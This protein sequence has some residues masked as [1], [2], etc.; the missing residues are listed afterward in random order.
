MRRMGGLRRYMPITYATLVAGALALAGF[1]LTAGFF[2]KDE[3]L[4]GT[5][6]EGYPLA[7]IVGWIVAAM[8]AFYTF[9]MIFMTF[10]GR[11]RFDPEQVHPHESPPVMTLPL[12]A[13]AIPSLLLGLLVGLPAE[14]GPI[15]QWLGPVFEGGGGH[16]AATKTMAVAAAAEEGAHPP[17]WLTVGGFAA[18]TLLSIAGIALAWLMYGTGRIS[19]Q[20]VGR[21]FAGLH[22]LFYN[23]WYLDD[24]Y[25]ALIVAPLDVLARILWKWVD[26]GFIDGIVNGVARLTGGVSQQ[27]R[28][29]QTGVVSNYALAIALGTVLI[30]GV[31]LL[32]GPQ[33]LAR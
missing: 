27:L 3:I 21:R 5:W 10:H 26:A 23:K 16:A 22:A 18:S 25:Q 13:L 11:P 12:I 33:F 19:P 28:K 4:V 30:V 29:V 6:F 1:P 8:T 7:A 20:A 2:S 15:H 24:I 32:F 9:R 17:A 14:A 31:Y